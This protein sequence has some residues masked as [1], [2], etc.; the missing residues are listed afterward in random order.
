MAC[1]GTS[2]LLLMSSYRIYLCRHTE[3]TYVVIQNLLMSSYRIYLCRHTEFPPITELAGAAASTDNFTTS[4]LIDLRSFPRKIQAYRAQS[5]CSCDVICRDR[6]ML[7]SINPSPPPLQ[8]HTHRHWSW[9]YE[10]TGCSCASNMDD[11]QKL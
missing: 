6:R 7:S 5:S 8:T 1:S 3:F 11:H 10:E 4:K 9:T 2:L